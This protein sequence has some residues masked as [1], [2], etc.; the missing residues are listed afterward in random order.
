M[1]SPQTS[2]LDK[3]GECSFSHDKNRHNGSDPKGDLFGW[4]CIL[5]FIK[6]N[7]EESQATSKFGTNMKDVRRD[8][9]CQKFSDFS[10]RNL[11]SMFSLLIN[12]F[13][14]IILWQ[15]VVGSSIDQSK[16][17]FQE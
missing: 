17:L 13:P 12:I 14:L 1:L 6:L 10:N 7:L 11:F 9:Y 16:E 3:L 2:M 8:T 4:S 15:T 5:Y